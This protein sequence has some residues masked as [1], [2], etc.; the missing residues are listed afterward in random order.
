MAIG[1]VVVLTALMPGSAI[2]DATA[3]LGAVVA[4]AGGPPATAD[5]LW[6]NGELTAA[7]P[8][9]ELS[10]VFVGTAAG[11]ARVGKWEQ[12]LGFP[13][14]N[15]AGGAGGFPKSPAMG[16]VVVRVYRNGAYD[17][18]NPTDDTLRLTI[19]QGASGRLFSFAD[20]G[21]DPPFAAQDGRRM[22]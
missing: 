9:S 4:E 13:D 8:Q 22:V 16:G 15:E 20:D 7:V 5:V 18:Q 12:M 2:G 3:L 21:T 1:D 10:K 6:E 14:F 17:A 19:A 11:V